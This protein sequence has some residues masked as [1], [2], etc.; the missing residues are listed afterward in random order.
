MRVSAALATMT[1]VTAWVTLPLAGITIWLLGSG[2]YLISNSLVGLATYSRFAIISLGIYAAVNAAVFGALLS[3]APVLLLLGTVM[4]YLL[5]MGSIARRVGY[6]FWDFLLLLV[7]LLNVQM[8]IEW[9]WRLAH[10][11]NRYWEDSESPS[12]C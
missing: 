4:T 11:P 5:L 6:R 9:I 8:H 7:P 12:L 3:S 1:E 2:A 10:L